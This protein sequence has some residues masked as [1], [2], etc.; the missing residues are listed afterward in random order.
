MFDMMLMY[1]GCLLSITGLIAAYRHRGAGHRAAHALR[2]PRSRA[3]QV[4][5]GGREEVRIDGL[6]VSDGAACLIAPCSGERA[7]WFRVRL[8]QRL[9]AAPAGAR[10]AGSLW[11]TLVDEISSTP[12]YV[13]DDSSDRIRV[14]PKY[15]VVSVNV[16]AFH[17][18]SS[19]SQERLSGFLVARGA[20]HV[21]ADVYEEECLRPGDSVIAVGCMR[22]EPAEP[23]ATAYRDGAS[24]VLVLQPAPG[25]HVILGT[26]GSLNRDRAGVYLAGK[27]A[28]IAG[29]IAMIVGVFVHILLPS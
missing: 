18:L 14:D 28:I 21:M 16:K 27:V 2:M 10:G 11:A 4:R 17:V 1:V 15:L 5:A 12:F 19:E 22:R 9:A 7:V 26:P 25:K 8:R 6:V 13:E 20:D 29:I 23:A 24:S 3:A